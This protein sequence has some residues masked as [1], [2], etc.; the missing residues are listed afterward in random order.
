MFDKKD[1]VLFL[2]LIFYSC[3]IVAIDTHSPVILSQIK[4][5]NYRIIK[6]KNPYHFIRDT[7]HADKKI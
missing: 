6:N 2:L 5:K 7:F 1:V 3:S 4:Y